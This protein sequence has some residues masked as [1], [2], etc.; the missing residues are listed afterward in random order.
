MGSSLIYMFLVWQIPSMASSM[1]S[2]SP[3]MT[4][5]SAASS[6]AASGSMMIGAGAAIGSMGM[7]TGSNI[8][9]GVK[10]HLNSSYL[11]TLAGATSGL[12]GMSNSST[13]DANINASTSNPNII[14]PRTTNPDGTNHNNNFGQSSSKPNIQSKPKDRNNQQNNKAINEQHKKTRSTSINESFKNLD[15]NQTHNIPQDTAPSSSINIKLDHTG[16]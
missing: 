10:S 13:R 3:N 2:G 9:R 4:A 14:N 1:L 16:D 12:S 8:T 11:E 5:G 6:I 7:E 15:K